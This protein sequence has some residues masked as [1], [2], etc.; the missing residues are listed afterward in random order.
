MLSLLQGKCGPA[1][2]TPSRAS[3]CHGKPVSEG[4]GAWPRLITPCR[5]GRLLCVEEAPGRACATPVRAAP[6]CFKA[7]LLNAR[8]GCSPPGAGGG[9]TGIWEA[10]TCHLHLGK[11][12][13]HPLHCYNHCAFHLTPWPVC[14][15]GRPH[16]QARQAWRQAI[17]RHTH[18][19]CV[20]Q[21]LHVLVT[22]VLSF[23]G[24]QG[25]RLYGSA[26]CFAY[27][28]HCWKN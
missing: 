23:W 12:E 22:L 27:R 5:L 6:T 8:S 15:K 17:R 9:G 4:L 10:A 2:R 14:R 21:R 24:R 19:C 13:S 11:A 1:T 7:G 28:K 3:G 26:E 18:A 16:E 25:E 20:G